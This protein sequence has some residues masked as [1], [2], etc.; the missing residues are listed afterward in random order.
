MAL[1]LVKLCVGISSVAELEAYR[2]SRARLLGKSGEELHVHRTRMMPRRAA[3]I[4]GQG[5]LYW[6]IKGKIRCRQ[7]IF[8]L[9]AN[10]DGDGKSCCDIQMLP[11]LVRTV[12]QPKRPF[13]GWRYLA[14]KDAPADLDPGE[15][16]QNDVEIAGELARLGL[17]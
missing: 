11:Q 9:A 13:Q 6:V 14:E 1:N 8:A 4:A 17:I 3:Q 16:Q 10:T 5:S 2:A 15:N 7:N 12:P